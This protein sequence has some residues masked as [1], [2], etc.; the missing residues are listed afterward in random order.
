MKTKRTVKTKEELK[1]A[2][3][4]GIDIITVKGALANSLMLS[5]KLTTLGKPALVAL[6]AAIAGVTVTGGAGSLAIAPAVAAT[7]GLP[8]EVI[9]AMIATGGVV[10]V[11]AIFKDYDVE[12]T[13]KGREGNVEELKLTKHKD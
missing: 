4:E 6:T 10:I 12:V 9:M 3:E 2:K 11:L 5:K 13:H 1:K 7:T 8:I